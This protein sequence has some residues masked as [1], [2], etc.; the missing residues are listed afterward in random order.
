LI[1]F[2]ILSLFFSQREASTEHAL[3]L[4]GVMARFLPS[5]ATARIVT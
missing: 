2:N 5:E 3:N 1:G 4:R